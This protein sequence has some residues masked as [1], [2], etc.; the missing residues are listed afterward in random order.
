MSVGLVIL[1]ISLEATR[2]DQL[3]VPM[4]RDQAEK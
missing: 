1:A 2:N 4:Y 3:R